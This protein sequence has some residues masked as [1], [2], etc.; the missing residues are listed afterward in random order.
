M[1]KRKTIKQLVKENTKYF[2][3]NSWFYQ[4]YFEIN[5]DDYSDISKQKINAV[6][7]MYNNLNIH[8]KPVKIFEPDFLTNGPE[9]K[10]YQL[11]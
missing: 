10:V 6:R 5:P 2:I 9:L 4:P 11:N 1:F 3:S 8:Y 7:Q